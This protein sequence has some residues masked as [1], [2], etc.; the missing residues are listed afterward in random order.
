MAEVVMVNSE[1]ARIMRGDTVFGVNKAGIEL[2]DFMK[3]MQSILIR[4]YTWAKE[5]NDNEY[6]EIVLVSAQGIK[7]GDLPEELDAA[8]NELQKNK[9]LKKKIIFLRAEEKFRMSNQAEFKTFVSNIEDTAIRNMVENN[10]QT[11]IK[12]FISDLSN[13]EVEMNLEYLQKVHDNILN[14]NALSKDYNLILAYI[15]IRLRND[16]MYEGL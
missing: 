13:V 9:R 14:Q 2:I 10:I 12:S 3:K 15:N 8:L 6:Y 16:E 4:K 11:Y 7:C 1:E 5:Q